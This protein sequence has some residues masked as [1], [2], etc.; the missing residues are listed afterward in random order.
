MATCRSVARTAAVIDPTKKQPENSGFG[1]GINPKN[2]GIN[3]FN[4][5]KILPE[6]LHGTT[7]LVDSQIEQAL[8]VSG[9]GSLPIS[10]KI[11]NILAFCPIST[12]GG[13]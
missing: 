3:I 10:I 13:Q 9:S 5:S 12:Q 8:G 1:N 11:K 7:G 6:S 2:F 4:E